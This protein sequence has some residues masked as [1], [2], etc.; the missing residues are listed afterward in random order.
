MF[1]KTSQSGYT[2]SG[3][4]FARG[5]FLLVF[6]HNKFQWSEETGHNAGRIGETEHELQQ[7]GY[8]TPDA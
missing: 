4:Q 5:S 2:R 8:T 6:A 3:E 1:I 7:M